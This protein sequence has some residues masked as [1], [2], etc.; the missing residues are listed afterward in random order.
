MPAGGL[1]SGTGVNANK[2]DPKQAGVGIHLL[3]YVTNAVAGCSVQYTGTLQVN[4]KPTLQF[5][6][7]NKV[8]EGNQVVISPI[9]SGE[10]FWSDSTGTLNRF[11]TSGLTF[12]PTRSTSYLIT[13]RDGKGCTNTQPVSIQ[14]D[15]L[16]DAGFS[17]GSTS[18]CSGGNATVIMAGLSGGSFSANLGVSI[19]ATTGQI[20]LANTPPGNHTITYSVTNAA[21][22]KS[23]SQQT[24]TVKSVPALSL[25]N[26]ILCSGSTQAITFIG[27]STGSNWTSN[28]PAIAAVDGSGVVQGL[29]SGQTLVRFTNSEG[30]SSNL[31]V[32][33]K[34]LPRLSGKQLVCKLDS[35]QV[36]SNS[37]NAGLANFISQTPGIAS[38]NTRGI[39]RGNRAGTAIIEFRDNNGCSATHVLKVDSVPER[40]PSKKPSF[41]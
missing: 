1:F 9:A 37:P 2:F 40:Q 25:S 22:C 16:P 15:P 29:Q 14:V 23:V 26:L 13:C 17:Y 38:V 30:C 8:C 7:L 6:S 27:S 3:T 19:N 5:A 35:I 20:N 39:V 4:P 31:V 33:V 10:L 41:I 12:K 28:N 34:D 21:G 32:T 18:F 24:I 36:I 11:T